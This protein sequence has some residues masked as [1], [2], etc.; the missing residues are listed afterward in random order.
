MNCRLAR[1]LI[2]LKTPNS[3]FTKFHLYYVWSCPV[4]LS[5]RMVLRGKKPL[6]SIWSKQKRLKAGIHEYPRISL[7]SIELIWNVRNYI[8][9][10][11]SQFKYFLET[12]MFVNVWFGQVLVT[13][14][15]LRMNKRSL[16]RGTNF[17]T[18][19]K[20]TDSKSEANT[21][22]CFDRLLN[23]FIENIQLSEIDF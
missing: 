23:S 15:I 18:I 17:H 16:C 20:T 21:V 22:Y 12:W 19:S 8:N 4:V 7:H 3:I 11:L 14:A 5:Q 1:L 13:E 2:N 6:L 9:I 10:F